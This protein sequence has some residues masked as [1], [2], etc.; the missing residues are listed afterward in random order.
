MDADQLEADLARRRAE[1]QSKAVT[2]G[3]NGQGHAHE[4]PVVREPDEPLP[5]ERP[6]QSPRPA[7]ST[8][9]VFP[10]SM[11]VA[12]SQD[13]H[14]TPPNSAGAEQGVLGS[15]VIS[16]RTAIPEARR[17]LTEDFFYVPAH[18]TIFT[19]LLAMFD[20]GGAIDLLTFT[21]YLR[22]VGHIDSVG[23]PSFITSLYVFVPTSANIAYYLEIVRDKFILR[24]LIADASETVRRAHEE[25]D[26][27]NTLLDDREESFKVVRAAV[28]GQ[29]CDVENFGFGALM[30]FD[31]KSDQNNLLGF[32]WLCRG[33][34]SLW[35]AA[36]G[37]G[38]SSLAMQLAITWGNGLPIFGI[39]PV[40]PLKSLIIQA[41][42]DLGDTGEQ[43]QGVMKGMVR[44]DPSMNNP[45]HRELTE[46]NVVIKRVIAST[47]MKFCALLETLIQQE[48]PDFVWIDPLFAFAGCDL[49]DAKE[50]GE[51][52]RNGIIPIAV[53][54]GVC[55]HVIHHVGK[56][57]KDSK[58]KA[59][60]T[61]LDF[62][63][64][65]FGSSEIQNSFRAVNIMLPVAGHEKK[66]RMIL[67]KRGSRAGAKD[68]DGEFATS[69]YL[70]HSAAEDGICWVQIDKPEEQPRESKSGQFSNAFK[71]D[72]ILAEMSAVDG[73]KTGALQRHVMT[74]TG[75]SRPTF[76][77]LFTEL[78]KGGKVRLSDDGWIKSV[79]KNTTE[80]ND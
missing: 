45:R 58:A 44:L 39:K 31:S 66:F 30:D 27:V 10:R 63:Y 38:K 70:A 9:R 19:D 7:R 35:A 32:R 49:K 75:M 78:K 25:Q 23:G 47:G 65:G 1:R 52:L 53:R 41:E 80:T 26:E 33:F 21:Q 42:N 15:M 28:A 69:L 11:T 72:D 6:A 17:I 48:L 56:P 62:Q 76:F 24:Q 73:L 57:D 2:T 40:R 4:P 34:T 8:A 71:P 59:G 20:A 55:L 37:A 68:P 16:P 18:Q 61:D 13:I 29:M 60:W 14:R 79:T 3:Q 77:R 50:A 51:F 64:L 67:A 74:E 43:L 54:H 12:S 36:A 22:D 5:E 46:R